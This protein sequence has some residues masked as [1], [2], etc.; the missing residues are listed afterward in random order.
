[1]HHNHLRRVFHSVFTQLSI[2]VFASGLAITLIIIV[3]VISLRVHSTSVLDRNLARYADYIAKDLGNPPQLARAVPMAEDMGAIIIYD[4]PSHG[5]QTAPPPERIRFK[6]YRTFPDRPDIS[7]G[8]WRGHHYFRVRLPE[9]RLT[10]IYGRG[11]FFDPSV[12][13]IL[14]GMAGAMVMVMAGAYWLVRC[15]LKPIRSLHE[16][17]VRVGSGD[18]AHRVP[19]KGRSE[20]RDLAVAFNRMT[21]R[22]SNVLSLKD[23]LLVDVSHELRSPLARMKLALAMMDDNETRRSLQ[24]DVDQMS[25]MIHSLLESA[26]AGSGSVAI[27]RE[28]MDLGRLIRSIAASDRIALELPESLPF[29]G[30]AAKLR[31]LFQNL[32]DNALKYSQGAEEPV[33]ITAVQQES[34][35]QVIVA[36]GG[37]GIPESFL[38][39]V[40]NPFF[41]VDD[42]R[43]R[44][45]GGF[46][47]G[48][49][50]C[51]AVAEAHGGTISIHSTEGA[52]T[53]VEVR[54]PL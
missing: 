44:E 2:A 46:G 29:V 18:L 53:R 28:D 24:E 48:L 22:L 7:G 25:T 23:R 14:L 8:Q 38:P 26:R 47:L 19:E 9:G 3:G 6:H 43:S 54:L 37:I 21:E 34:L 41:R 31:S 51:K 39:H 50:V 30:D 40:F 17:A 45:T 10:L 4:H 5:W 33:R 27:D 36:D 52:G 42:S 13:Y 20:L 15:A 16:G 1:M 11:R 12:G 49:S 32:V 35:V